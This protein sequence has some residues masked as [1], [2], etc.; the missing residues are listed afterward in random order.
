MLPYEL[1][2][3]K[4]WYWGIKRFQNKDHQ[5]W[6]VGLEEGEAESFGST[7]N[8]M[9][10]PFVKI[11]KVDRE[12][13]CLICNQADRKLNCPK[14]NAYKKPSLERRQSAAAIRSKQISPREFKQVVETRRI[15]LSRQ[16]GMISSYWKLRGLMLWQEWH[17]GRK[18]VKDQH[19]KGHI[20]SRG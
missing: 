7:A 6:T 3:P 16:P 10:N 14:E 12:L 17:L 5:L 9:P 19:L 4:F 2:E 13:N 18:P 11:K 1:A 20:K 15:R 8:H